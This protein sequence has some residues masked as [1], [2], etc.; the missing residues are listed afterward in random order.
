M[1]T[2]LLFSWKVFYEK[3]SLRAASIARGVVSAERL[4]LD[5][6]P[7]DGNW[8]HAQYPEP[9]GFR[10]ALPAAICCWADPI[11][12]RRRVPNLV[13]FGHDALAACSRAGRPRM[14]PRGF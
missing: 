5:I 12:L 11:A 9:G 8:L 13:L 6:T 1:S 3:P 7:F 2:L 10:G 14:I 4:T